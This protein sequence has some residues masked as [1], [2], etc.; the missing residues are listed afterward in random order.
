METK[1]ISVLGL[2]LWIILP[3]E[4]KNLTTLKEFKTKIS[5]KVLIFTRT[6][7][8]AFAH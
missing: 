6:N 5:L 8:R 4:Y 1:T 7:F 2:K 3:D